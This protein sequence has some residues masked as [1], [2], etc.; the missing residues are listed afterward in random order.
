[1]KFFA[2]M[3]CG[4]TCHLP[5]D[6]KPQAADDDQKDGGEIDNGIF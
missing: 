3:E 4:K 6:R 5:V 2:E 1:M